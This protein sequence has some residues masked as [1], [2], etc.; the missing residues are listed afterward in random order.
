MG[1]N[2][3]M[4]VRQIWFLAKTFKKHSG[5]VKSI[6][7]RDKWCSNEKCPPQ[8]IATGNN[9]KSKWKQQYYKSFSCRKIL[10]YVTYID[11][12]DWKSIFLRLEREVRFHNNLPPNT[13]KNISSSSNLSYWEI[14][15]C[16]QKRKRTRICGRKR[17]NIT[18]AFLFSVL[19]YLGAGLMEASDDMLVSSSR[20]VYECFYKIALFVTDLFCVLLKLIE[21]KQ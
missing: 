5:R 10:A 15:F 6:I 18:S 1:R 7:S 12:R 8:V 20:C 4:T 11:T 9:V 2:M 19:L 16:I 14:L 3:S 13:Y 21:K 17:V